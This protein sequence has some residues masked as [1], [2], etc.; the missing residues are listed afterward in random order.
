MFRC[1]ALPEASLGCVVAGIA[2][3]HA[4]CICICVCVCVYLYIYICFAGGA[5][6][7]DRS[8][9]ALG[10]CRH[11]LEDIKQQNNNTERKQQNNN[12]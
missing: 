1:F 3:F 9:P 5:A 12:T 4:I 11:L 2:M 6:A 10:P 7:H 8:P